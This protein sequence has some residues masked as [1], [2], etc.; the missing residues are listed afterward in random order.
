[1]KI[2][3]LTDQIAKIGG[4][5]SLINLKSNYW[6]NVKGYEVHIITTEQKNANPFYEMNPKIKLY[7][8]SVNYDRS[9]SYFG[10]KNFI[11]VIKNYF[12]LQKKLSALKPNLVIVANHIP[13]TYFFPFLF[14]KA[15]FLKEFHYSQFYLS[16]NSNSIFNKVEKYL[17][18][19]FDFLVVL[20]LEEKQF[21]A[22]KN[23]ITIPN[24]INYDFNYKPNFNN[25]QQIAMAAGRISEVKRF[26]VLIDIWA[27]FVT[28][29]KDWKLEIYGEGDLHYVNKLNKK[30]ERLEVTEYIK[31]KESIPNLKE[32][33]RTRSLYMMT[34]SME[35]F[36]M[37]LLEAFSNGLPVISYNCPTGPRNIITNEVDGLLVEMDNKDLFLKKLHEISTNKERRINLAK[38]GLENSMKFHVD[39]IM[40]IWDE[41]IINNLNV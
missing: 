2:V 40:N 9:K 32:K 24:P 29:N 5:T 31:I 21:Y 19:K 38:K 12:K 35:C 6:V 34:S 16:K 30:I 39:T 36:P 28:Q 23:V 25:R 20:S 10:P 15:K 13:V 3:I 1:M 26:D 14:S 27:E 37:V 22:H 33:M 7:D 11:K 18:S 17:E 41:K 8:L 4:I